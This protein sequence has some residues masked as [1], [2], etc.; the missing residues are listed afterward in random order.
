MIR[1]LGGAALVLLCAL[2]L[3]SA[4]AACAGDC[5]DDGEVTVDELILGVNIALGSA[6]VDQC[7]ALDSSGDRNLTINELIGAVN[8]ALGGCTAALPTPAATPTATPA[9]PP[10]PTVTIVPPGI[11]TQLLGTFRGR[12]VNERT[13][14]NKAARISIEVVGNAVVATDLNGNIFATGSSITMMAPAPMVIT[15]T[16]TIGSSPVRVHRDLSARCAADQ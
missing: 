11:S 16:K 5:H 9:G 13:G 10:A 8:N 4:G 6:I 12:A 14:V 1:L 15:S 3:R 2:P 7:P